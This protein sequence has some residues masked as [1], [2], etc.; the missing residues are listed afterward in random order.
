MAVGGL[1]VERYSRWFAALPD[2]GPRR[3]RRRVG[4]RAGR[5][6]ASTTIASCSAASI[7]A[8]CSSP[9]SR[10]AATATTRSPS[11]TRP[12][13]RPPHHY[14]AFYRWLDEVW[15]ADAIVHLGKHGTLEWLPGKP[16]ALTAGVLARRRARRRP[17]LLPVRRQRSRG[18]EP[19]QAPRPRRRD[20][21]PPAA[22]DPR[23]HLRRD[24]PARAA[25][26]RVR[27]DPEPRPD[28]AAGAARAH[29]G[30]RTGGVDRPR[31]RP[32]RR[33]RRGRVRRRHRRRR[34]LPVQPQGRPDPRRPPHPRRGPRRTTPSSISSS[35][36]PGCPTAG[37]RRCGPPIADEL[38]LDATDPT[39]PRRHRG[40]VPGPRRR[41]P[42]TTAGARPTTRPPTAGVD[43][44]V[45]GPEP[46]ARHRRDRQPARRARRPLRARR[47]ERR[48]HARRRPRAADR[49]QLL[50]P[51]PQGP[52]DPAQ[53]GRRLPPGRRPARTPP[54]RGGHLPALGR[55]S[56]CGARR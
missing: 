29:L 3:A 4:P 55:D 56:C 26:R 2:C 19:G 46:A 9:S 23:R 25:V 40:A 10:H 21:P 35:P 24:G 38:G 13:S 50:L 17:V 52:P 36:S 37:C 51:R 31:P 47:P 20:R 18:G 5:R 34:R 41:P 32:R 27:P 12:T 48:P 54:G 8:T 53:L 15:G 30:H 28:E 7:S 14:L 6:S 45:A 43:L 33:A 16:L 1:D 44:R 42:P 39:R 49:P 11:T 22:D